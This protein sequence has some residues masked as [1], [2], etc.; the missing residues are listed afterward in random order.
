MLPAR[1]D[2]EYITDILMLR[3]TRDVM[4]IIVGNELGDLSSKPGRGCL[5]L[6]SRFVNGINPSLLPPAMGK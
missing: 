3:F 1:H 2:D 5:H 4:A 6:P